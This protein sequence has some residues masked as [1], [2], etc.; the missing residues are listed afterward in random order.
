MLALGG[1]ATGR[2]PVAPSPRA[3]LAPRH[4]PATPITVTEAYDPTSL[5]R[6]G[7]SSFSSKDWSG[8]FYPPALASARYLTHYATQFDA[9][10]VD[11][12][13]YAV[14][15]RSM[16]AGWAQKTPE[17]FLLCA[18][19]PRSIVHCG[20]GARPD[21]R[22]VLQPDATYHDRDQFLAAMREMGPKLGPLLLQFPYFNRE[23]FPSA[24]AFL[25]R[26]DHFLGDLP[27]D[28]LRYAVEIRNKSWL[29]A[30]FV[31][32]L[33]R[34]GDSLVLVDQGWMPHG[35]EVAE[36]HDVFTGE[37]VYVRLLGD[38]KAIEALTKTWDKEVIDQGGAPRAL[39]CPDQRVHGALGAQPRLRQQPLRGPC[40]DHRASPPRHDSQLARRYRRKVCP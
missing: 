38:R 34:H 16:V 32:L 24:R 30:P 11:S 21:A 27:R 29:K 39:G 18:K 40:T 36:Q 26:L 25:D 1:A 23:A 33:R 31:E 5:L 15:R 37:D 12:T 22:L 8:V 9:V 4:D 28:G 10:E 35:D 13:Y 7:T 17:G 20:R 6:L 14:P 2:A 19:F 3:S